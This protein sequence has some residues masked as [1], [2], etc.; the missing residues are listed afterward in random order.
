MTLVIKIISSADS[1]H[2]LYQMSLRV[3][4]VS[5][6]LGGGGAWRGKVEGKMEEKG[7]GVEESAQAVFESKSEK[8]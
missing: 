3:V 5:V 2:C 8:N 1:R 4:Q 7:R 6:G